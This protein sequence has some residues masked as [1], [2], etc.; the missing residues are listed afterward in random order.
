MIATAA[1]GP[2]AALALLTEADGQCLVTLC[3]IDPAP[4]GR[5]RIIDPAAPPKYWPDL[6]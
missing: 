6:T 4:A 2:P 1:A 5:L 3:G